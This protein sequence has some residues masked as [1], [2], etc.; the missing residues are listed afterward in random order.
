M[1]TGDRGIWA[2]PSR[3]GMRGR[4]RR[5]PHPGAG[6]SQV[7]VAVRRSHRPDSAPRSAPRSLALAAMLPGLSSGV[8]GEAEIEPAVARVQPPTGDHLAAGEEMHALR[9]VGVRVTEEAVLPP[10]EG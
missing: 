1:R 8:L 3:G 10:A 4:R 5:L 2:A 7:F 6:R 9:A